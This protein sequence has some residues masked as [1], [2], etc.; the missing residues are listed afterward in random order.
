MR[1]CLVPWNIASFMKVECE[2]L[3]DSISSTV[4]NR[5]YVF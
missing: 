4:D 3:F 5:F 2:A 1:D